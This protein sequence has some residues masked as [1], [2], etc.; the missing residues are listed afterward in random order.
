MISSFRTENFRCFRE[1]N[2]TD[3]GRVN[4]LVGKNAAGKTALL[5]AIRL[6][7]GATPQVA[8]GLN[9]QRPI[10]VY[11]GGVPTNE[12]FES[13]WSSLFYKFDSSNP[14]LAECI[15]TNGHKASLQVFY[16][17][18]K[19]VTLPLQPQPTPAALT[20]IIPLRF[21]RTDFSGKQSTLYASVQPQGGLS[22]DQG[23]ELGLAT[24]FFGSSWFLNPQ[25]NALWFSQLSVE[26]R[27]EEV[28]AAVRKEF[29]PLVSDLQV[30]SLSQPFYASIYATVPFLETKIPL[31]LLSAGI[32][33]FFT[34]LA[35]ILYRRG[36][37]VLI[38]E[39]ENGLHFARFQAL[40]ESILRL[41][42]Q[43][44]TQ[45]FASTHSLE[46][47][48]AMVPSIKGNESEF[49]LL[50][51]ERADGFSGVTPIK[52]EFFEASLEQNFELR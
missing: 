9:Q 6:A 8:F 21:D 19:P 31:S 1:I 34:I 49:R 2:L 50:H 18:Q 37:V 20:T 3:C 10:G 17:R 22:M 28:I 24:E 7:L 42:K 33:K 29:D 36:G 16:D 44:G 32:N 38:D 5:E 30:L 11:F 27:E 46:C 15:D 25:Q 35:A 4:L 39:I 47:M 13:I 40:W 51:V 14:I 45:I 23:P 12:Q 26:N 48:R 52:G 43:N 41:G